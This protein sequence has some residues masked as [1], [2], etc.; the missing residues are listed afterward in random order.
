MTARPKVTAPKVTAPVLGLALLLGATPCLAQVPVEITATSIL[1]A[2]PAYVDAVER[3]RAILDS[4]MTALSF[5]GLGVAVA[6]DGQVVWSEGLGLADVPREIPVDRQSVFPIYSVSKG[7]TGMALARLVEQ[8][9]IDLDAPVQRYVPGFPEK[10]GGVVTPRLLAGHL[11]GIRHYRS[12]EGTRL[13][14]CDTAFEAL[15]PFLNDSLVHAPG[16]DFHYTSFGFVLLSAAMAGAAGQPFAELMEAEVFRPLG[17]PSA[18]MADTRAWVPELVSTH[19]WWSDAGLVPGRRMNRTCKMGAGAFVASAEDLARG[20]S[21]MFDD[22]YLGPAARALLLT[23]QRNA[24]GETIVAGLGWD[25]GETDGIRWLRRT[26]GNEDAW[27]AV[28]AYPDSRVAIALLAN[29]R[30]QDWIHDDADRVARAFIAAAAG[31]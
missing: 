26:G 22:E 12:G 20:S 17:M 18:A 31:R 8:G 10:A 14:H 29:M 27:S 6:V 16:T 15:S 3:G 21:A 19:E 4:L 7:L 25:I 23:P 28:M 9:R 30:G 11:A 13:W 5:P 24:A 1:P 2:P